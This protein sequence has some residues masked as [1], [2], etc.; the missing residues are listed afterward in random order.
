MSRSRLGFDYLGKLTPWNGWGGFDLSGIVK[1]LKRLGNPQDA[2]PLVHVA[3]TNGKGS[4]SSAVASIMGAA[5]FKV[6]LSSSPHLQSLNERIVIDGSPLDDVA[7]GELSCDIR[8]AAQKCLVDLSF[9]EALTAASFLAFREFQ[10]EWGVVEVGLGGRLDASNVISRPAATCI[11]TIDYDH[12]AILG[13]TLAQIAAE[14]AGIIKRG[15]PLI[16]GLLPKE[17]A[18]TVR[19]LAK[20]TTCLELGRDYGYQAVGAGDNSRF[21]YWGKEAGSGKEFKLEFNSPL[22]GMHQGHNLSVAATIGLT[23]G[24]GPAAVVKGLEQVHWPG[25]LEQVEVDGTA[26]LMDCAHNP[27]GIRAFVDY[28]HNRGERQI[29]LTFGVLDTKN[30]REMISLLIPLVSHWRLLTPDSE[31]ALELNEVEREIRVSGNEIRVS[32]YRD[33]YERYLKEILDCPDGRIRYITGSMYMIGKIRAMLGLPWRPLW[34]RHDSKI[35]SAVTL[36]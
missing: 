23:L 35:N 26:L 24:M 6:G 32:A 20:G 5:G 29:D 16:T 25:R 17:A 12:Q 10:L 4:V 9:H 7:M 3:G 21:V 27:A 18:E 15:T 31:R 36:F 33:D 28:L 8:D 11:V 1:V 19:R 14:K 13:D 30:W 2:L 22:A 34:H